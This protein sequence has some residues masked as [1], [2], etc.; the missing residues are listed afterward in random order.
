[1]TAICTLIT[2]IFTVGAAGAAIW[3]AWA[4]VKALKSSQ[5]SANS[6]RVAAD[7][8]VDSVNQMKIDSE[9]MREDS[10]R[11]SRPYVFARV[12]PSISGN[13]TW[14]LIVENFGNSAAYNVRFDI[15]NCCEVDHEDKVRSGIRDLASSSFSLPP[16]SHIRLFFYVP[17]T[18]TSSPSYS[19]GFKRATVQLRYVDSD[20]NP[21][22]DPPIALDTD[23]LSHTPVPFTGSKATSGDDPHLRN[24]I[25]S[26]RAISLQ[27]GELNR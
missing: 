1:M 9:R 27:L 20:Q 21:Y 22:S 6:S 15:S 16:S 18:E 25:H 4:A 11:S 24:I 17:S 7:A 3:A 13:A 12:V 2:T 8:A 10:A 19:Q 23:V 14:D 26:L 5:A